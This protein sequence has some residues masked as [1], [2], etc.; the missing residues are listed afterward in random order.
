MAVQKFIASCF[1]QRWM[2]LEYALLNKHMCSRLCK[3]ILPECLTVRPTYARS[4]IWADVFQ[5]SIL[6]YSETHKTWKF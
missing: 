6:I 1:A 4:L 3:F 2:Y 5:L